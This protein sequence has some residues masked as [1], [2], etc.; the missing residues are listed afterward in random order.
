MP[1]RVD[2]QDIVSKHEERL[3]RWRVLVRTDPRRAV[4]AMKI[5]GFSNETVDGGT[6]WDA[7]Y[8]ME[9]LISLSKDPQSEAWKRLV[10][11]GVFTGLSFTVLN[12]A[13]MM[14]TDGETCVTQEQVEAKGQ[15]R[16]SA[17]S[18]PL[19]VIFHAAGYC[20]GVTATENKMV[21]DLRHKWGDMMQRVWSRPMYS[22]LQTGDRSLERALVAQIAMR[23]TV[24]D[25]SFVGLS[26]SL[27][28]PSDFTLTVC[29]RNWMHATTPWDMQW[30]SRLI[31]GFLDQGHV[32]DYWKSYLES[33]P[34]PA[35]RHLL[36][37]VVRGAT[38][39]VEP[40]PKERRRNPQQAAEAIVDAFVSHL[41]MDEAELHDL[42]DELD[43][44]RALFIPSKTDYRALLK[45][46][47]QST[48]VCPALVHVMRRAYQDEAEQTYG[49]AMQMFFNM[50]HPLKQNLEFT[51]V[52]IAHWATSGLFGVLEESSEFLLSVNP[53]PM[54]FTL[55][56]GVVQ[57]SIPRLSPKTRSF[58][59]V[60]F[61]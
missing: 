32:S 51:D 21:A 18:I 49:S 55:L 58:S 45:A 17:W 23:L 16:P 34:L 29:F 60:N 52:V 35:L 50:L 24:L 26:S 37:R 3:V 11:A 5:V 56:M 36:L 14:A 28:K 47:A 1:P 22:L 61:L 8:V 7:P 30:N 38:V 43:F 41:M 46:I 57:Q 13:S 20:R 33:H 9:N 6:M 10:D 19:R 53:G 54:T 2:I 31:R 27:A 25:P 42:E 15:L 44:F 4:R 39:Y 48:T 59:V 40:G 12:C